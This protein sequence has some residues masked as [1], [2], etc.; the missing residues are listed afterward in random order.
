MSPAVSKPTLTITLCASPDPDYV[1]ESHRGSVRISP[2]E[3]LVSTLERA[4]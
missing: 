4:A 2:K 1:P 3:F